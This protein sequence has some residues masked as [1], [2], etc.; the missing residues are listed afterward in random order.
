M[1]RLRGLWLI[2][3]TLPAVTS[4]V[5]QISILRLVVFNSFISDAQEAMRL[6]FVQFV[7]DPILRRLS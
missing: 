4:G 1:A 7:D 2:G 3:H 6:A 5:P